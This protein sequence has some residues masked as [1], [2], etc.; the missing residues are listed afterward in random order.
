[1]KTD[2]DVTCLLTHKQSDWH[3]INV[4]VVEI[5]VLENENENANIFKTP[6]ESINTTIHYA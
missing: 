3:E 6:K 5:S 4:K 2:V 1:M